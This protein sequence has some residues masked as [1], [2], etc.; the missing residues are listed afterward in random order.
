MRLIDADALKATFGMKNNCSECGDKWKACHYNRI[1]HPKMDFCK[2]IDDAP[3]VQ[4]EP[5]TEIQ[6]ILDY[7]DTTLHPIVS[8]DNWNVYSELHDMVS[9]LPSAQLKRGHWVGIDDEPCEV[10]ECDVCGKT[11]D[12]VGNTWDLPYYCPNCGAKME[13]ADDRDD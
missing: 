7:L 1:Y 6:E 3:T 4:P 2:W 5:S 12:T 11:Y 8:P 13:D 10:Y 9:K